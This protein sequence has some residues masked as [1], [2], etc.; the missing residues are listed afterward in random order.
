M[1]RYQL[2]R[3]VAHLDLMLSLI[4]TNLL[5]NRNIKPLTITI[6]SLSTSYSR[7]LVPS[8]QKRYVSCHVT[9]DHLAR[10]LIACR[11]RRF[12]GIACLLPTLIVSTVRREWHLLFLRS[13]IRRLFLQSSVSFQ[14]TS[15]NAAIN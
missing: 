3:A 9:D 13:D 7:L 1:V 5:Q 12:L 4:G 15:N 8:R 6:K 10:T 2:V 14:T 11:C